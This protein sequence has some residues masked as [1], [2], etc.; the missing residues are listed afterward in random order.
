MQPR[1]K[2]Q[3]EVLEFITRYIEKHGY[4]P[5][6][7]QIARQLGIASKAGIAKH[8]KSLENQ[9]LVTR[10]RENGSFVLELKPISAIA[11]AVCEIEWLEVPKTES[12]VEEW[13][14]KPLFVPRFLLGFQTPDRLRA[15][16]VTND[17]MLNEHIC[18]GDVALIENRTYARDGD[19]V[20]ALTQNKRA[21]L[22]QFFRDGAKVELRPANPNYVSILLSADKVSLLGIVRGILRPFD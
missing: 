5:S 9:G 7:Q 19:I 1:T 15:Y 12:F 8:I 13:E 2:R 20:V 6:Y 17:A 16:R 22:K 18:E 4:K 3:K 11:E 10:R 14:K 21:V